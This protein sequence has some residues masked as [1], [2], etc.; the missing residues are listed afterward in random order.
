MKNK[1]LNGLLGCLLILPFQP[2]F[3]I[4]PEERAALIALHNEGGG[5]NWF[6]QEDAWR[7]GATGTECQWSGVSCSPDNLNVTKLS[8]IGDGLTRL[9]PEIGLL[10]K[11][12][13]LE[14]GSNKLTTLPPEI[15]QLSNLTELDLSHNLLTTLPPEIGQLSN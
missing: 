9:P 1:L 12:T 2:S 8:L 4:P 10:S 13:T 14:L 6:R 7:L 5:K 11:L 3:A 15:A